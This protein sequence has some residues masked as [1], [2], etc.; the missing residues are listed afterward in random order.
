[1][2]K[3]ASYK[4]KF[5][6]V[7]QWAP[8]IIESIKKDIKNDHLKKDLYFVKTYFAG[9][10]LQKI[11]TEE[12]TEAYLQA[13]EKEEKA[14]DI[15]EFL[16]SCWLM[17]NPE[18]YA[19]FENHLSQISEDFSALE[20]LT[21]EQTEKLIGPAVAQFGAY[22]TY[23]F[24]VFNSVVFPSDTFTK[25]KKQ[26][27]KSFHETAVQ[28]KTEKEQQSLDSLAKKHEAEIAR[29]TDKHEKKFL[30]L[31]K[32]YQLDQ[33]ALKKQVASLQRKLNELSAK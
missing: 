29:L 16:I 33:E 15:A 26:A 7:K 4:E 17:K 11:T 6:E 21:P 19:L 27:E 1:M 25:L 24:S 3:N 10:N 18:L 8:N 9:K 30:G 23:L 14:E 22:N 20:E 2:Y 12:L 32:K 5:N 13:L 28:Q 31:Q